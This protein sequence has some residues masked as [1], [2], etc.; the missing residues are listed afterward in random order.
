VIRVVV[1]PL[2]AWVWIGSALLVLGGVIAL[3]RPGVLTELVELRPDLRARLAAPF[4]VIALGAFAVAGAGAIWDAARAVA[5]AGGLSLA[6]VLFHVAATL[7]SL[8]EPGAV[9]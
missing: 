2:V 6:A 3:V 5:V 4:L 8:L 1:N 9:P 7:R